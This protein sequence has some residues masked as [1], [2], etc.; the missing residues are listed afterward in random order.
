MLLVLPGAPEPAVMIA[1]TPIAIAVELIANAIT[2][3]PKWFN[4]IT[5]AIASVAITI[6]LIAIAF[7]LIANAL[8]R[9][10]LHLL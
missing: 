8:L 5:T 10:K 1:F 7:T 6:T 9:F 3:I 4:P 2:T